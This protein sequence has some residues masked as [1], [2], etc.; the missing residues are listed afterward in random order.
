MRISIRKSPPLEIEPFD[1]LAFAPTGCKCD[2]FTPLVIQVIV[3]QV[4]CIDVG[5]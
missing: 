3:I 5:Y 1:H 2:F 4:T